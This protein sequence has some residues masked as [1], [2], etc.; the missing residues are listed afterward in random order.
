MLVHLQPYMGYLL[1]NSSY[2]CYGV[3]N[4]TYVPSSL[5]I[6]ANTT[7]APM[8]P[9]FYVQAVLEAGVKAKLAQVMTL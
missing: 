1:D 8:Q 2:V 3:V 4:D 9:P 5:K 6:D 7:M